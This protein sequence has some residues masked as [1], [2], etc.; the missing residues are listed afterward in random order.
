MNKFGLDSDHSTLLWEFYLSPSSPKPSQKSQNP[1]KKI[2]SWPAYTKIFS[3]CLKSSSELFSTLS[4]VEQGEFITHELQAA[5]MSA[6]AGE[7]GDHR[8]KRRQSL[9]MKKL[10]KQSKTIKKSLKRRQVMPPDTI[11]KLR[12]DKIA[13]AELIRV[14]SYT[15]SLNAKRRIEQILMNKGRKASQLFWNLVNRKPKKH[16]FIEALE[17]PEGL[18]TDHNGMNAIIE[19]FFEKKF[20]TSFTT[21]EVSWEAVYLDLIGKPGKLFT[22]DTSEQ[23][24]QPTTLDELNKN[25]GELKS[26]KVEGLDGVTNDMLKNTDQESRLKI[27]EMFNNI[28]VGGQVPASW[29]DGDVVLILKK[30]PQTDINNYCPITLISNL[31][32]L[33]TKILAKRLAEAVL[34]DYVIGPEQDG[35]RSARTCSDNIFILNSI[36]EINK[37]K[38]KLSHLLCV[39]LKEAYDRVDRN[40]LLAK[41]KQLNVGDKFINFLT[42]YYF[43]DNISTQSSG[44][45]TRKQYQKQGLRQGCNLSSI[46][47]RIYLSELSNRMR[48]QDLGIKLESG[49]VVCILLFADDIILVAD[50]V[51]SLEKL[52]KILE[53]WCLD[54]KMKISI[55]KT[56]VITSLEDYECAITDSGTMEEEIINH[57]SSYKYLGVT[58]FLTP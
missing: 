49:E 35:F 42:S 52:R 24:M 32:K 36:L 22:D 11:K 19:E 30:P 43:L 55:S 18:T 37:S 5:G 27:I 44:Q 47:F 29:K 56:N 7:Q 14:Q 46:L 57:V 58:Q 40:I 53:Q 38:K 12:A 1:L 45:R 41:L 34:K 3:K 6:S 48:A 39:D 15:D 25:I 10:L 33:L 21:E 17:S 16:A 26:D 9:K 2:K 54:F 8:K 28:I 50:S 20:N 51:E 31:S 23:I 4:C 13:V